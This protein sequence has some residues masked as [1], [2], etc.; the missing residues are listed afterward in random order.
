M[1]PFFRC[2]C[3]VVFFGFSWGYAE[4]GG[5]NLLSDGDF[6]H[7][8]EGTAWKLPGKGAEIV[9]AEGNRFL[10]LTVE[11]PKEAV[12]V[13]RG[14]EPDPSHEAY[15]LRFR[16][17]YHDIRRGAKQWHD[18]RVIVDIKNNEGKKVASPS[19]PY[20][21]K[22]SDGWGERTM[23][24]LV[25]KGAA[26]VEILPALLH[27]NGGTLDLDDFRL[28]PIPAAP[29]IAKQKAE[30]A[31]RAEETARRAA[32]VKPQ[33]PRPSPEA[34]PP[35]LRVVGTGIRT[36]SGETVRLRG[37]AVPSLEWVSNGEHILRSIRVVITEWNANCIRLPLRRRFWEGRGPYQ[38]DGGAGYRQRVEDAANLCATHGAYLIV[39]LHGFRAPREADAAFWTAV[40][41]RLG[42]HPAVLFE[43]FNAPHDMSWAVWRNGGATGIGP[44]D[45]YGKPLPD[46]QAVGMQGL[47][48]AVR[49]AG[50]E[51]IV[52]A[53]GLSGGYD[54]AGVLDG[55]ALE[56]PGGRG[57]V[58]GTRIYPR[59]ADWK[60]LITRAAEV[61]PVFITEVGVAE[62]SSDPAEETPVLEAS[63]VLEWLEVR[64]IPWTAWCFHPKAGPRLLLDWEYTPTTFWGAPVKAALRGNARERDEE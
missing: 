1:I 47:L 60:G 22:S 49:A 9:D 59:M 48:E 21:K 8:V 52:I 62:S 43:L 27:A 13:V 45:E 56:D 46:I 26:R 58:Y 14:F 24:F 20:F 39:D 12:I 23:D 15:R 42:N 63:E 10:R 41:E 18:G 16:V 51:N 53:N 36:D 6:E 37:V 32:R 7:P 19:P 61:V 55:H 38:R 33:V 30:A 11:E 2:F 40:A 4:N 34:M 64:E 28:S 35:P 3:L 31:R 54:L 44:P 50:A 57:V 25:P 17:R 29:L 5:V